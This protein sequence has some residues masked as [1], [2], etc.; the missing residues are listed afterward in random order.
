MFS[1]RMGAAAK[2]DNIVLV[3]VYHAKNVFGLQQ[4]KSKVFLLPYLL[5]T[6]TRDQSFL[7]IYGNHTFMKRIPFLMCQLSLIYV[8]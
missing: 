2:H 5:K 4:C 6:L 7:G 1:V 8:T 3:S